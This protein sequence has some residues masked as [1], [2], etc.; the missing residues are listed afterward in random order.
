MTIGTK[1]EMYEVK[2]R[3]LPGNFLRVAAYSEGLLPG[4]VIRPAWDKV[5]REATE[6]DRAGSREDASRF[7]SGCPSGATRSST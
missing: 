2:D 1:P 7:R 3:V 6:R 4:R 5:D